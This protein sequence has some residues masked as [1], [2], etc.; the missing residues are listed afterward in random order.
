MVDAI[1]SIWRNV[2][3]RYHW[4]GYIVR[5]NDAN[6]NKQQK[7]QTTTTKTTT[8]NKKKKCECNLTFVDWYSVVRPF[9]KDVIHPITSET[10]QH[11]AK[12]FATCWILTRVL[13]LLC[14]PLYH[15]CYLITSYEYEVTIEISKIQL[16]TGYEYEVTIIQLWILLYLLPLQ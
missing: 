10:L 11:G 8:T 6:N 7:Q 4:N 14:L 2:E 1:N 13:W 5:I 12:K 9:G 3:R 16:I 15:L